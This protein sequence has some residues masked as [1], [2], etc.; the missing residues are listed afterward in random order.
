MCTG[1]TRAKWKLTIDDD[2]QPQLEEWGGIAAYRFTGDTIPLLALL[3]E[4][5]HNYLVEVVPG[6]YRGPKA[7]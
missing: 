3:A 7:P 2:R 5:P 4:N 1:M 6:V